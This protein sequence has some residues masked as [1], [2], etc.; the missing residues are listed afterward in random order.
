MGFL[1]Y[2]GLQV[3]VNVTQK[4][5]NYF[6]WVRLV[7][8]WVS[9]WNKM[10]DCNRPAPVAVKF[11]FLHQTGTML[12][13][14]AFTPFTQTYHLTHSLYSQT[15]TKKKTVAF[16]GKQH[17]YHIHFETSSSPSN[18][19]TLEAFQPRKADHYFCLRTLT[20]MSIYIYIIYI[21]IYITQWFRIT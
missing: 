5:L 2:F 21:T 4:S 16:S 17:N 10:V 18:P 3:F 11:A 9:V 7:L 8:P 15:K 6:P 14:R 1:G 20:A 13:F 19:I 12:S